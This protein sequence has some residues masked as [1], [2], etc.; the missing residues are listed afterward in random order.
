MLFRSVV[1][2]R[3]TIPGQTQPQVGRW[4]AFRKKDGA[5][6][7]ENDYELN[8]RVG[9]DNGTVSW[10]DIWNRSSSKKIPLPEELRTLE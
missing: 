7:D 4:H 8:S 5:T 10:E 1:P 6:D 9:I 2:F 3:S